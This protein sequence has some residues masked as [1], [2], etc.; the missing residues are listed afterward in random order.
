ML[1]ALGWP[2]QEMVHPL[3]IERLN[4][5][6]LRNC[7][8]EGLSPSILT[9]GLDQ[10]EVASALALG[11]V[12]GAAFEIEE[13]RLRMSKGLGFNQWAL[14]SVAG[15]VSFDPLRVASD[16][17][18]TERFELQ[19]GEMVNGRLAMLMVVSYA[20]IEASLHVP[21]VSIAPDM[22]HW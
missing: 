14:D 12:V 6:H 3:I 1:A 16:M 11:I 19:Q 10:P 13:M 17:P 15:D 4:A 9:S 18:V 5:F 21:I 20:I 7:L 22:L 8:P 2:L